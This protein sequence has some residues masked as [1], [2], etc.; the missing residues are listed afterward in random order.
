MKRKN[1]RLDEEETRL[2]KLLFNKTRKFTENISEVKKDIDIDRKPAWIDDD[3]EKTPINIIPQV[4]SEGLYVQ[5]LKQKYE[6]LIGT[7]SWAKV[8]EKNED[9]DKDD[10]DDK[11]LRT[12]G[13]LQKTKTKSLKKDVLEIKKFPKINSETSNEGPFISSVEFHPKMSV[14]LVGGKA[15][16]VSLFSIGGDVNNKLHSFKLKKFNVT[17]SQFSPDGSE[18][19]IASKLCHNYCVYNLAKAEPILVQLPR[20]VKAAKI[21]K[22]SPDGKFIA[23]S[24]GFDEIYIICANSKELLRALKHNTNVESVVFSNNSENLYC[25]GIQGEITVWDL[26]MFRSIKKFTDNGCINASK[27]A[28]SH[29]GQLLATGSGEGIVNIYDTKNLTTQNPL[30]LK[31]IMNLTTKITNLKF[32]STTEILSITSSYFPNALKLIHIPSYHVFCNFPKQNLYQVETVSF[33][34]NSGY[35]GIGNNKGCAY[36][37]RLK[38]FKNY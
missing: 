26:S 27:I 35:M 7:P 9:D 8:K 24:D 4:K 6:T 22:L 37:Y 31:T 28:M 13:H 20:I 5:K 34:P 33:S 10:E 29:C 11:L 1:S 18:A 3:D 19:Y 25:Y 17:T 14:V 15:G 30:P 21:F 38:H 36:L 32:N 2:S 16:I 12:V 23:T